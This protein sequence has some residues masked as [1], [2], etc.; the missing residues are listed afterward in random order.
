MIHC[1]AWSITLNT[2]VNST[3]VGSTGKLQNNIA[4][5]YQFTIES[6]ISESWKR[7][8]GVK[9]TYWGATLLYVLIYAA[10]IGLGYIATYLYVG[11]LNADLPAVQIST[12]ITRLIAAL[13]T[14][15]LPFGIY[16]LALYHSVNLP[17][18]VKQML[19]TYRF[20]WKILVLLAIIYIG[21]IFITVVT[22]CVV[23]FLLIKTS[24]ITPTWLHYSA[25]L[26][27]I[28]GGF[29]VAYFSFSLVYAPL[30]VIEKQLGIFQAIK[31]SFLAFNQHGLKIIVTM[32]CLLVIL[33]ISAIPL[34]IGLIWTLPMLYNSMGIF[35]RI[36]FG[37][38]KR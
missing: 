34:G 12:T 20:Y 37:V 3:P 33:F 15:P 10:L 13:I 32:L 1:L 31:T 11:S 23:I 30:L 26:A 24:P 36:Q 9:A 5:P 35:Y 28:L 16:L 22:S 25:F 6:I 38:E 4:M 19:K 21:V 18:K 27:G 7:V 8:K 17:I 2:F 14:L 29:A